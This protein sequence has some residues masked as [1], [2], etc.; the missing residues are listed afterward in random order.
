MAV[1]QKS[2][3]G[4]TGDSM[5]MRGKQVLDVRGWTPNLKQSRLCPP[6][7]L[8]MKPGYG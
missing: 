6:F 8:I 4:E 3:K 2:V 1:L 7:L 5:I